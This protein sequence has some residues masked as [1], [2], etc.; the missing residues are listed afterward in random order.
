M[1]FVR[2]NATED[3]EKAIDAVKCGDVLINGKSVDAK[4][5]D[6]HSAEDK[7]RR[8]RQN[9]P[10]SAAAAAA[11]IY[12]NG[13][14]SGLTAASAINGYGSMTSAHH[15]LASASPQYAKFLNFK[16]HSIQFLKF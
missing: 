15:A 4:F 2:F 9:L 12:Q 1:A 8:R 10:P 5:A 6:R 14:A 7:R 16:S 11:G 13:A 3:A